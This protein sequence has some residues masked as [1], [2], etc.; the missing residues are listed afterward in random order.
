MDSTSVTATVTVSTEST[1]ALAKATTTATETTPTTTTTPATNE[2]TD[3]LY[4][5]GQRCDNNSDY[6][7]LIRK[8][9]RPPIW[10]TTDWVKG[11]RTEQTPEEFDTTYDLHG[12]TWT[13]GFG[14]LIQGVDLDQELDR[15]QHNTKWISLKHKHYNPEL[16]KTNSKKSKTN[17]KKRKKSIPNRRSD[18]NKATTPTVEICSVDQTGS[19]FSDCHL[20]TTK[21]SA[22]IVTFKARI[23]GLDL[24]INEL[25][26]IIN[27]QTKQ[28]EARATEITELKA[29]KDNSGKQHEQLL[30]RLHEQEETMSTLEEERKELAAITNKRQKESKKMF[31]DK[32]NELKEAKNILGDCFDQFKVTIQTTPHTVNYSV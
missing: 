7:Y 10:R 24:Q 28:I 1:T 18:N 17:S 30:D 5:V 22:R 12:K 8:N 3:K 9:K 4:I 31:R 6:Q 13:S 14:E 21:E 16:N 11:Q 23:L 19:V 20:L 26:Q 29:H 2:A 15:T 25:Q 32:K 27:E